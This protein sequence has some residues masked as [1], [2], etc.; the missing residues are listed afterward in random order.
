MTGVLF[1]RPK[2]RIA[3]RPEGYQSKFALDNDTPLPEE[4]GP[5][6]EEFDGDLNNDPLEDA[7]EDFWATS[8]GMDDEGDNFWGTSPGLSDEYF[9]NED[10]GMEDEYDRGE[11]LTNTSSRF[12]YMGHPFWPRKA[13]KKADQEYFMEHRPGGPDFGSPLHNLNDVFPDI[14]DSPHYYDFGEEGNKDSFTA[15]QR[16]KGN[17]EEMVTMYRSI[18]PEGNASFSPG[19]WVSTSGDYARQH[20]LSDLEEDDDFIV[21]E[22]QVPASSLWSEGN[23]VAEWGY[24]G[25]ALDGVVSERYTPKKTLDRLRSQKNSSLK[26]AEENKPQTLY[27][28]VRLDLDPDESDRFR[29]TV[30]KGVFG[31]SLEEIG[32]ELTVGPELLDRMEERGGIGTHWSTRPEIAERFSLQ[33]GGDGGGLPV[34]LTT[35]WDGSGQDHDRTGT[36]GEWADEGEVT[37]LPGT[38][39]NVNSVTFGSSFSDGHEVLNTDKYDRYTD[40]FTSQGLQPPKGGPQSRFANKRREAKGQN[41]YRGL[42]SDFLTDDEYSQISDWAMKNE[43]DPDNFT[44]AEPNYEMI[45]PI[46]ERLEEQQGLG[47][48]WSTDYD[49]ASGF[50]SQGAWNNKGDDEGEGAHFGI[51]FRG[52]WGGE[53]EDFAD[54]HAGY[55]GV[56]RPSRLEGEE[57]VT[58][59][60]GSEVNLLGMEVFKPGGF[61]YEIP[62]PDVPVYANKISSQKKEVRMSAIS[63]YLRFARAKGLDPNGS[64]TP[65]L[66]RRA[67]R[68]LS[69]DSMVEISRWRG[70]Q[71]TAHKT[72]D[73]VLGNTRSYRRKMSSSSWY[74]D[75]NLSAYISKVQQRFACSCGSKLDVPSYTNCKCGKVWNAYK[76]HSATKGDTMYVVREVPVRENVLI[77]NKTSSRVRSSRRGYRR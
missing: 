9:E 6:A 31:S 22:H 16:A 76:V 67:R 5:V 63:S 24:W 10:F 27:R 59:H 38:P 77:A 17:P 66:Y 57:E 32:S 3:Y 19:D 64:E 72:A 29:Q 33:S 18:P 41:L 56:T 11:P 58:L 54:S 4:I 30:D 36:G 65:R 8:P 34:M 49:V 14:Y 46:L 50:A 28:G 70:A 25:D 69:P 74:L 15:I 71:K 68:S 21:M 23:S 37:L 40:T 12:S 61:R 47:R 13:A 2:K 51:V 62:V 43:F 39:L 42:S 1:P 73:K 52:D 53:G 26:S 7:G 35:E 48:H 45:Y 75:N 44:M 60:P 20:S 55:D